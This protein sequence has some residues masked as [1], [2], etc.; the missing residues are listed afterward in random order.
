MNRSSRNQSTLSNLSE[1]TQRLLNSY[2]LAASAAGV[3][4]LALAMRQPK[5]KSSTP[6]LTT[7]SREAALTNLTSTT[8]EPPTS[9]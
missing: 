7:S 8:T 9:L 3:S 5:P 4:A 2:A 1:S 6:T